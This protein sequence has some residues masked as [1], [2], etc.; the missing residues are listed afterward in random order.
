M[1]LKESF[2]RGADSC[3]CDAPGPADPQL[4]STYS[5]SCL[6][7]VAHSTHSAFPGV[8][9]LEAR[10]KVCDL[11]P[12]RKALL[13]VEPACSHPGHRYLSRKANLKAGAEGVGEEVQARLSVL[14]W[15][16]VPLRREE[17]GGADVERP[18]V[19]QFSQSQGGQGF[20]E[21]ILGGVQTNSSALVGL[22]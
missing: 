15:V 20:E 12:S 16:S 22:P 11:T 21:G 8:R 7:S 14:S 3:V 13:A 17:R 1:A 18:C 9:V 10:R 5:W 6:T 2:R 4:S 19:R